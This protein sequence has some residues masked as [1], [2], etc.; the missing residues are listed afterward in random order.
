[1][2]KTNIDNQ[3][4]VF[5][6]FIA[7]NI[8]AFIIFIVYLN[9]GGNEDNS[10]SDENINNNFP[11]FTE[12]DFE[13]KT[14][15]GLQNDVYSQASIEFKNT[16]SKQ[17]QKFPHSFFLQGKTRRKLIALTFDDAPDTVH[18]EKVLDILKKYKVKATFFLVG[19]KMERHPEVTERIYEEGH[20]VGNHSYSHPNFTEYSSQSIFKE[21]ILKTEK[22]F[23]ETLGVR[24]KM[25]RPPYGQIRDGQIRQLEKKGYKIINWSVDSFDWHPKKNAPQNI[26]ERVLDY[27]HPGAVVLLHAGGLNKEN[28]IEALPKLIIAL[29]NN[30]YQFATLEDLLTV[31]PYFLR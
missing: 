1:M 12:V 11:D 7:V 23:Q 2:K 5:Y 21:Q 19:F 27:I 31:K 25:I 24:P 20:D 22:L 28:T 15:L 13:N 10:L 8:L 30:G 3:K 6:G 9:G 17:V 4:R 29:K 26:I 16:L 14:E 18:T